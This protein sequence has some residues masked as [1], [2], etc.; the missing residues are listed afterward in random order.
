[1]TLLVERERWLV[2]DVRWSRPA[3]GGRLHTVAASF[4]WYG[5]GLTDSRTAIHRPALVVIARVIT[6]STDAHCVVTGT[7]AALQQ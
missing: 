4:T 1:M 7:E 5:V 2:V 6:V 3:A